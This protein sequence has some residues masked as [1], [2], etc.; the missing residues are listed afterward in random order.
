MA[1][2]H[3]P[4]TLSFSSTIPFDE[5]LSYMPE[6]TI[7]GAL[8]FVKDTTDAQPGFGTMVRL[9]ADGSH[10]PDLSDFALTGQGA[11]VNTAST[12]NQLFFFYDGSQYCV[13][14]S[15][16]G[17]GGTG[18]SLIPLSTPGSFTATPSGADVNLTW[19]DVANDQGY[20]IY[21]NA[22]N[23]FGSAGLATTTAAN[24]TSY[25][26]TGL[27]NGPWYF[28][29]KAVGD[30]VTYSDSSTA[31]AN[32][33]VTGGLSALSTPTLTATVISS[34]EIDLSWTNVANESSYKLEWSPNGTSGWTQIGGT[35]AANTTTYNHTGLTAATHYYYRVTAVGDG[36]SY[37]DSGYGTDDDTTSAGA[38]SD[39]STWATASG[40]TDS[41]YIGHLSTFVQALKTAGIFSTHFDFLHVLCGGD[42]NKTKLSLINPTDSDGAYRLTF[43]NSPTFAAT[44]ITGDGST[45]YIN[46]HWIGASSSKATD[47][48]YHI[49]VYSRTSG[50][51]AGMTF[52]VKETGTGADLWLNT[53][54]TDDLLYV[55]QLNRG[56]NSVSNTDGSG[57]YIVENTG[58][59][60]NSKKVYKNNTLLFDG[61]HV[62]NGNTLPTAQPMYFL[63]YNNNSILQLN[64]AQEISIISAGKSFTPTQQAAY[65]SA[66]QTLKTALG[67]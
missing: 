35:I 34:S 33:T 59:T 2:K 49:A 32:A 30:G 50:G 28:W 43:V 25:S 27:S 1:N 5:P 29:I 17:T 22:V 67:L 60:T 21:W 15:Q 52:C 63:A 40:V 18:G 58:A 19:S 9:V 13:I 37:S 41:T 14:I 66:V 7:T 61:D 36:V 38:D 47:N 11:W 16:P 54:Y 48:D 12:V 42:A 24:A 39:V 4:K 23:D 64:R 26:K 31:S 45:N 44:G 53:R 46:S 8:T 20:E 10:S 51:M 62:A 57:F 56:Q 55:S 65:N 6:H 3:Y